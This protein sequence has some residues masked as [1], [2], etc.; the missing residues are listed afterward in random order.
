MLSDRILHHLRSVIDAPN[1]EGTRYEL[2]EEIGRGGM[3]VVYL[4]R[5][6]VLG[7]RVALKILTNPEEARIHNNLGAALTQSTRLKFLRGSVGS[8]A[9]D[10]PRGRMVVGMAP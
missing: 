1:L 9:R 10:A 7:R 5:D 4:A 6:K 2:I 3:G 8:G